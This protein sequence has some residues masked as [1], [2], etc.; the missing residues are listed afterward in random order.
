[1][2]P[3]TALQ[4]GDYQVNWHAVSVDTHKSEGNYGFKVSH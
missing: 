3:A 1:M 4:A 2:T